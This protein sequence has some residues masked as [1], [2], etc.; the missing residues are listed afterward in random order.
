MKKYQAKKRKIIEAEQFLPPQQ[1]PEGVMNVYEAPRGATNVPA[2]V[3]V[4]GT[5][6]Y[7]GQI[8]T[9]QGEYV[10]VRPGEWIVK[11]EGHPERYYP[12]ADEIFQELYSE[13]E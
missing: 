2:Q 11:E 12:I 1:I 4:K 10:F 6:I 9:A 5:G 7:T 3:A 13:V 8:Q